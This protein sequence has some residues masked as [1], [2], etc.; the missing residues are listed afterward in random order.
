MNNAI[1]YLISNA[2]L[3][4]INPLICGEEK[5]LPNH[6]FGPHKRQYYLLHYVLNGKG[7]LKK[8]EKI[9]TVNAD[10]C[11][12]I[13]PNE[14]TYYEA[15]SN[16]PWHYIWIGFTTDISLPNHIRNNEVFSCV[17]L[18]P[19][20]LSLKNVCEMENNKEE[21]LSSVIFKMF[22]QLSIPKAK[23]NQFVE[24]AKLYIETNYAENIS[25]SSIAEMLHINRSYFYKIFKKQESISPQQ[26]I[27]LFRLNQAKLMLKQTN[28]TINEIALDCGFS[29]SFAFSKAYKNQFN[30]SPKQERE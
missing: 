25:V 14:I 19:L 4:Y 24:T 26:Y 18:R 10:E 23:K 5:C 20:F 12:V 30:Y 29:D 22:Q 17:N 13:R 11:F 27:C 8:N 7:T 28:K 1:E 15:D 9:Y 21:Y 2:S 6:S 3:S 16:E